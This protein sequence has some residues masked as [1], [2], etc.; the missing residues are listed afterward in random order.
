MRPVRQAP[1]LSARVCRPLHRV[2][3]A[4]CDTHRWI[5]THFSGDAYLEDSGWLAYCSGDPPT[6]SSTIRWR[7]T[8]KIS[9]LITYPHTY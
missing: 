8:T 6:R 5:F 3:F 4:V 1:A 7:R 2:P 9:T